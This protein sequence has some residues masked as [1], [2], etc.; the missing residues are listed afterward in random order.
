MLRRNL[1]LQQNI[2][3]AH[4]IALS[5]ILTLKAPI[6]TAADDIHNYYSLLFRE[7]KT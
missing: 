5:V 6:K 7:N 3:L 4:P 2:D 1:S